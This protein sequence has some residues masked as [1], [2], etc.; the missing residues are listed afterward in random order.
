MTRKMKYLKLW[1]DL[2]ESTTQNLTAGQRLPNI[3]K[4][5]SY[6]EQKSI[7]NEWKLTIDL[8]EQFKNELK[9]FDVLIPK[10]VLSFVK[11]ELKY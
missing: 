6:N 3:E 1:K 11:I 8:D 10:L 9:E 2:V 7:D 4:F 5:G